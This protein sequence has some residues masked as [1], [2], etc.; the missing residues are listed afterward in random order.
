M[1]SLG[2]GGGRGGPIFD[3][4]PYLSRTSTSETRPDG[5]ASF[6]S[7]EHCLF[8]EG[9]GPGG[10]TV[11]SKSKSPDQHLDP[12]ASAGTRPNRQAGPTAEVGQ[13]LCAPRL[14][15]TS[16]R[17]GGRGLTSPNGGAL[18]TVWFG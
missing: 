9:T 17:W 11:V 7:C 5:H 14:Q 18:N 15:K 13:C 10:L 8:F 1:T 16:V 6:G 3:P 4:D 2:I 12:L